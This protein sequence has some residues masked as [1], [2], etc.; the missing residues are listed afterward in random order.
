VASPEPR[1]LEASLDWLRKHFDPG[2]ARGAAAVYQV[3]LSGPDGGVFQ[4]EVADGRLEARH[5]PAARPGA[6]FRL[7]DRDWFGVLSGRENAD[8]LYM[9]GRIEVEGDLALAVKLRTF[10][11]PR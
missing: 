11:A 10:F 2:S 3:E 8:L 9:A 4:V 7:A 5:G 6:V 1:T